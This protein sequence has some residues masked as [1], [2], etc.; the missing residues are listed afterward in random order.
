MRGYNK[1]F[2]M[3]R[4]GS[5]PQMFATKNGKS[6][7]GLNLATHRNSALTGDGTNRDTTDWHFVRVYGTAAQNCAKYLTKG[8]PIF[9]EGYLT[10][11]KVGAVGSEQEKRTG[12]NAIKVEFLPRY[13]SPMAAHGAEHFNSPAP[14]FALEA[15][16]ETPEG[17]TPALGFDASTYN[18][19]TTYDAPNAASDITADASDSTA[20][21]AAS[22]AV[23]MCTEVMDFVADDT[24]EPTNVLNESAKPAAESFSASAKI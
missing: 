18:G 9:V 3:G 5:D 2:L 24:A 19:A 13:S 1:L 11:Y 23:D 4:L 15:Q 14:Q 17:A 22:D 12:I 10:Q 16:Q 6:Y 7:V 21:R 20:T 8:H